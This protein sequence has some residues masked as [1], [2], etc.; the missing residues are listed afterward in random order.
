[1]T[2]DR[3]ATKALLYCRVS[4]TK[5]TIEGSTTTHPLLA[6]GMPDVVYLHEDASALS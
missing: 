3:Q 1:M 2:N 6:L 5:Q 4:T